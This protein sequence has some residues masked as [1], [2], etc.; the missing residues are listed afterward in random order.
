LPYQQP[1][2]GELKQSVSHA[3]FHLSLTQFFRAPAPLLSAT[4]ANPTPSPSAIAGSGANGNWDASIVTDSDIVKLKQAG[5]LSADIAHRAPEAGQIVPTPRPG[6]RVVFLPHFLR[7]LGFP[8]HPFVRGLMFFY[9]LDF[10]DLAPNS[11]LHISSFIS[12]C[13][14]LLRV[15]PH[16]GL[17]L[18]VFNVKPKV[19]GG[20]HADCGGA[21]ISKLT[22]VPWLEGKFIDTVKVWQKE[23]FYITKPMGAAWAAAPA[24]R[25]GPPTRL[26]TW[27]TKSPDWGS[28][29]DLKVLQKRVCRGFVT[30]DVPM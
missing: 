5:Y 8:L 11:L 4:T 25:S 29:N 7:G 20:E 1:I 3:F 28:A 27:T 6:D 18:K 12:F 17:W 10:H 30:A 16:F 26:A 21:M 9:G 22:Q 23:W 24:F 14:A 15:Q 2:K 19:V 13:E